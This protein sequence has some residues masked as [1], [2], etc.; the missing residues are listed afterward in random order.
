MRGKIKEIDAHIDYSFHLLPPHFK[1]SCTS[2]QRC[3]ASPVS[4]A[5]TP[6]FR[7]LICN[8]RFTRMK[9]NEF[10]I[11]CMSKQQHKQV[12][13]TPNNLPSLQ[14]IAHVHKLISKTFGLTTSF[15][16]C[17]SCFYCLKELSQGCFCFHLQV[18]TTVF[19]TVT[20]CGD[21]VSKN[22]TKSNGNRV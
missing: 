5:K 9:I 17:E 10:A 19:S 11:D 13:L 7:G 20:A 18:F 1:M 2:V 15:Q 6:N 16:L 4:S 3:L 8:F 22:K 21:E 12:L 14:N